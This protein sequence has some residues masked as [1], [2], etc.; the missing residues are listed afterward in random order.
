MIVKHCGGRRQ[1]FYRETHA[2][3]NNVYFLIWLVGILEIM[4]V[5]YTLCIF[6]IYCLVCIK[7]LII[8]HRKRLKFQKLAGKKALCVCVCV[9]YSSLYVYVHDLYIQIQFNYIIMISKYLCVNMMIPKL[10]L[11]C[12]PGWQIFP[13]PFYFSVFLFIKCS[14]M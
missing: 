13:S 6:D 12:L 11:R 1:D 14:N 9:I 4:I 7:Y 3:F 10:M 8:K 5:F 2:E